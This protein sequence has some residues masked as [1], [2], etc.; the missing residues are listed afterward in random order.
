MPTHEEEFRAMESKFPWKYQPLV[1]SYPQE[2]EV[3]ILVKKP[4][5]ETAEWVP[6]GLII[7]LEIAFKIHS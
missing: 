7:P 5:P 2:D 1:R 3:T 4:S 6:G